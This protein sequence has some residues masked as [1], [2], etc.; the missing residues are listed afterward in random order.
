MVRKILVPMDGSK[1]SEKALDFAIDVAETEKAKLYVIYVVDKKIPDEL[2]RAIEA[3]NIKD[4]IGTYTEVA[5]RKVLDSA[6][7]KA[8]NR[9][10]NIETE[11]VVGNPAE[12]IVNFAEKMKFDIVIIGS[13]GMGRAKQFLFGSVTEKVCHNVPCTCVIVK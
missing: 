8:K 9:N 1:Q 2:K 11:S 3:A 6:I 10:I 7:K 5:S 12:E 13:T 4:I